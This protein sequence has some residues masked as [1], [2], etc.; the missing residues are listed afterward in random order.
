MPSEPARLSKSRYLSGLQCHKQLWW[1]VHEPAAPELSP[2]PG[3]QNRFAPG[4]EVGEHARA[5]G[6]R[7]EPNGPP[8]P[9]DGNKSAAPPVALTRG[10]PANDGVGF[11]AG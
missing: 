10:R 4:G 7:A 5:R 1:R 11:R 2:S 8:Y 9:P 6:P 3:E